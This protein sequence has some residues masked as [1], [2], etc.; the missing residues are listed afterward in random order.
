MAGYCDF[1]SG[2]WCRV[3]L[4][5]NSLQR[6]QRALLLWT[7]RSMRKRGQQSCVATT[8]SYQ[9]EVNVEAEAGA[10]GEAGG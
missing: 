4:W 5:A 9:R 6:Q 1:G 10:G 7:R 8:A 3:G 2:W